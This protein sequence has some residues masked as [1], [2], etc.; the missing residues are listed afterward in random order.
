MIDLCF[1]VVRAC[2]L[3]KFT[4]VNVESAL[5]VSHNVTTFA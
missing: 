2:F 3:D 5:I 1:N 4:S